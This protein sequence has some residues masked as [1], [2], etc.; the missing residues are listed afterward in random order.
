VTGFHYPSTRAVNSGAVN[1]GSGNRASML[2]FMN[3]KR[4]NVF[5]NGS[6]AR[7]SKVWYNYECLQGATT[8]LQDESIHTYVA[9]SSYFNQF[10]NL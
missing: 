6:E 7:A 4:L 2:S 8:S 5:I 1:S 10:V 9:V 3:I